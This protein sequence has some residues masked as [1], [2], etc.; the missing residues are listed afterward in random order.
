MH[1]VIACIVFDDIL[2]DIF[3]ADINVVVINIK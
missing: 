1:K 2:Y 3:I